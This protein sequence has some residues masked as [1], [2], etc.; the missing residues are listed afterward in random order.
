MCIVSTSL[1]SNTIGGEHEDYRFGNREAFYGNQQIAETMLRQEGTTYLSSNYIKVA[2]CLKSYR[3]SSTSNGSSP[4]SVVSSPIDEGA[5]SMCEAWRES[6]C[7]WAFDIADRCNLDRQVAAVCM[8]YLD[9]YLSKY[10]SSESV[11]GS[12]DY[13]SSAGFKM[14]KKSLQLASVTCLYIATKLQGHGRRSK[15]SMGLFVSASDGSF[16]E[17]DMERMEIHIA[18]TL[19]WFMHPPTSFD[20]VILILMNAFPGWKGP[21]SRLPLISDDSCVFI[22]KT[23][24]INYLIDLSRFLTELSICDYYFVTR[25]PSVVAT[26]ALMIAAGVVDGERCV[27]RISQSSKAILHEDISESHDFDDIFSRLS[28]LYEQSTEGSH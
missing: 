21:D 26:A 16:T 4:V 11:L 22:E 1:S 2:K 7:L 8:S 14:D 18:S 20:F 19:S 13:F 10:Y 6:I 23:S 3:G 15:L 5:A 28:Q 9:R 17:K 24:L 27:A 25:R 12:T